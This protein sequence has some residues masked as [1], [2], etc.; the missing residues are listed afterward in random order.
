M[1]VLFTL[2]TQTTF[3]ATRQ[4]IGI[5]KAVC[6]HRVIADK[7]VKE[8]KKAPKKRVQHPKTAAQPGSLILS[9]H[10]GRGVMSPQHTQTSHTHTHT[11]RLAV[12]HGSVSLK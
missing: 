9:E 7:R 4:V 10:A 11:R 2:I 5:I 1:D 3:A 12:H 8:G 6:L